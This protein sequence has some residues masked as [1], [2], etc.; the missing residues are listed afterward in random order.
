MFRDRIHDHYDELSPSF[1]KLAD[2]IL[3]EQL[4]VAFMTATELAR[5]MDIDAAT[6]VRF[7]QT[8]GYSGF[9]ELISEIQD[10]VRAELEAEYTA[11]VE[12]TETDE[13]LFRSL[14]ENEKHN[15]TLAQNQLTSDV[16]KILPLLQDA[17]R[18]WVLGQG[19][20][21]PLAEFCAASFREVGL[22]A[23]ALEASPL[24]VA[25]NLKAV[26]EDD[27][28]VGLS[29]SGMELGVADAMAFAKEK[30]AQTLAFS[31]SQITAPALQTENL[32]IAPASTQTHTPSGTGL[33]AM[34]VVTTV[35]INARSP[36][37][38]KARKEG[39]HGSYKKLLERQ[40]E[41]SSEITVE[42][43]WREF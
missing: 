36:E 16:E 29:L 20:V 3:Q 32:L 13:E 4:E 18:I 7:A 24:S 33:L 34:I 9:R 37:E 26:G 39:L 22:P 11:D 27:L 35:A 6:V 15:L 10:V 38:A 41:S 17:G 30:G 12:T 5:R 21:L 23:T 42:E 19:T 14:L 1:R 25:Q 31:S 28:I 43:L 2:F 8:L 40:A